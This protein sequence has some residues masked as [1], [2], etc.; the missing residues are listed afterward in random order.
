LLELA[1]QLDLPQ[2]EG[3]WRQEQLEPDVTK[4]E[5]AAAQDRQQLFALESSRLTG[6]R[7]CSRSRSMPG[8]TG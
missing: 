3:T 5:A 6:P 7:R 1:A 4:E 8:W 2:L